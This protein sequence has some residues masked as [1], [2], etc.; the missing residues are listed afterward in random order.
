M[1]LGGTHMKLDNIQI[2]MLHWSKANLPALT[3][4]H[5]GSAG[6]TDVVLHRLTL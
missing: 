2:V 3:P 6:N 1:K 5:R 4:W